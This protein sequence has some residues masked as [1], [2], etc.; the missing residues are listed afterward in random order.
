MLKKLLSVVA[1]ALLALPVFSA[2][3]RPDHPDSYTVR[4]GDTLWDIS[5]KF[6]KSPWYWPEIWHA[7]PQVQNPHL[8]YPGDVLSLVYIDGKPYLVNEGGPKVRR[9]SL[10][11]ATP[12]IPLSDI[13]QF[14]E[15]PRMLTEQEWKA[16]PYVVSM[17]DR[18]LVGA[19]TKVTY[20]RQMTAPA[21]TR[22]AVAR[23]TMV[24]RD[25][26]TSP[27]SN[28]EI[29][30]QADEWRNETSKTVTGSIRSFWKDV[31]Y[32]RNTKVLGY[33]MMEIGTVEIVQ[34]GDP[35]SAY[36]RYAD[37]EI[38]TGDILVP[39]VDKPFDFEFYPQAPKSVPE[40]MRVLAFTDALA[41]TGTNQVVVLNRGAKS[42]VA[43]GNVFSIYNPGRRVRDEVMYGRDTADVRTVF[44]KDKANVTL[45]D[46]FVGH[47]MVFRTFDEVSYGLLI[48]GVRPVSL[49]DHLRMPVD[50]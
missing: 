26:P 41:Y 50:R 24:Y 49:G 35:A 34:A 11:D 45:P 16:A 6:L 2:E 20:V 31:W 32:G 28:K 1:G 8:I 43:N 37:E 38:K 18:H 14:L 10:E 22:F 12:P 3:L 23:P 13:R 27:F 36:I 48:D 39:I 25:V 46:E 47:V 42:N 9:E 15:R 29:E 44:N 4:R 21:G 7:N 5:A 19:P 33:E 40:N 30:R 17:E